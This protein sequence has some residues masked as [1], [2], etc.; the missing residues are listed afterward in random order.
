MSNISVDGHH[1]LTHLIE[2]RRRLLHIL[3]CFFVCFLVFFFIAPRLFHATVSSLLVVLPLNDSLIATHM[4]TA[5]LTPIKL[6]ANAALLVTTPYA[7]VHLW[8]FISPG[9]YLRERQRLLWAMSSSLLLFICGVLFGFYLVL[10]YMFSFFVHAMPDGVRFM[11][12]MGYA[13]DFITHMLLIFGLCFQV[14]LVCVL[15]VRM[16]VMEL[17]ALKIIRPYVIVLAFILGMLLTPPDVLSQIMLAVPLCVLY[18]LGIVFASFSK[19]V[20]I[21]N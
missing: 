14:P 12:D 9:L 11:P 16:D 1:M 15:L 8:L 10:P 20:Q 17:N 21:V 13:V 2:C 18:E 6:A 19:T 5:L 4:T 7:L 3:S